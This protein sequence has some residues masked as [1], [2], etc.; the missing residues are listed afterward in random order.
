MVDKVR[1]DIS[2]VRDAMGFPSDVRILDVRYVVNEWG[3]QQIEFL[4]D[5]NDTHW[6][7]DFLAPNKNITGQIIKKREQR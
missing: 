4:I 2:S 6:V 3:R 7:A 5:A 1:M